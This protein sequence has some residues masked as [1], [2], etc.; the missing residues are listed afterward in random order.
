MYVRWNDYTVIKAATIVKAVF[1]EQCRTKYCYALSRSELG[2]GTSIYGLDN[3]GAQGRAADTATQRLQ[4]SLFKGFELVP[5]PNC[6]AYQTEM[7]EFMRR[8]HLK[9]LV[10]VA[11]GLFASALVA[12]YFG[13]RGNSIS[14]L[15]TV[16]FFAAGIGLIVYRNWSVSSYDPNAGDP[17]ERK[18]LGRSLALVKADEAAG[19]DRHVE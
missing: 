13:W 8:A 6:G 2:M 3:D 19:R 1:C 5:C 18:Q 12:L 16:V 7:V 17:E 15:L 4:E 10:L 9:W 14:F 11:I